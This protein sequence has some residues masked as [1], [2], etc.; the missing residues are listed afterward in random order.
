MKEK[1]LRAIDLV[2]DAQDQGVRLLNVEIYHSVKKLAI[3]HLDLTQNRV[4]KSLS[5]YFGD[6][7]YG[8][9][10][11]DIGHYPMDQFIVELENYLT[12]EAQNTER[13]NRA[14]QVNS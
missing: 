1:I 11:P 10:N 12:N 4:V 6:D 8:Y 2:I 5:T 14:A 9:C 13:E 7:M 3:Y